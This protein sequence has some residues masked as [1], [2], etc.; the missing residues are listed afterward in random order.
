MRNLISLIIAVFAL[1][2]LTG[3]GGGG[4]GGGGG[5]SSLSAITN[6]T[7]S[8]IS[9]RIESDQNASGL[10]VFLMDANAVASIQNES[11]AGIRASVNTVSGPLQSTVTD[12]TGSF[13]FTSV[14]DGIYS[15]V[16]Q[17]GNNRNGITQSVVVGGSASMVEVSVKLTPTGQISGKVNIPAGKR[18][19]QITIYL[20]GTSYGARPADN[21]NFLLTSV[22][23]GTFSLVC[24]GIGLL[25]GTVAN[26]TVQPGATTTL[27][28]VTLSA[29]SEFFVQGPT[30]PQG[31]QGTAGTTGAT[32][33][34]GT[35]GATGATG[36]QGPQGTA[37]TTGATGAQGAAGI[38]IFW[39]GSFA[40][41][42]GS[43]LTNHAYY[44]TAD[45]KSYIFN[46]SAWQLMTVDGSGIRWLNAANA[47]PAG[48]AENDAYRNT[49][50][51]ASYIYTRS[52][53][54]NPLSALV[55]KVLTLPA[56]PEAP[57][58]ASSSWASS[59][60]FPITIQW[61]AISD[62]GEYYILDGSESFIASVT[63]PATTFTKPGNSYLTQYSFRVRAVKVAIDNSWRLESPSSEIVSATTGFGGGDGSAQKPYKIATAEHL[64][65]IRGA[66][67]SDKHFIQTADIS[68]SVADLDGP[69]WYSP[70]ATDWYASPNG[71]EPISLFTGVYDGNGFS[72]NNMV[73]DASGISFMNPV[74]L[75][76]VLSGSAVLKNITMTNVSIFHD[77]DTV[78]ALVGEVDSTSASIQNCRMVSGKVEGGNFLGSIV[79]VNVGQI[80]QCSSGIE[81]EGTGQ[82]IG[83]IVGVN[84]FAG[85]IEGCSVKGDVEGADMVG[86]IAGNNDGTIRRSICSSFQISALSQ[87]AGGISG[88]M[89]SSGLIEQCA[90]T[91]ILI[92]AASDYAGGIAGQNNAGFI[93]ESFSTA[94]V[95]ADYFAGGIV[96]YIYDGLVSDSYHHGQVEVVTGIIGG[97]AGEFGS[98]TSGA[99]VI[100]RCYCATKLVGGTLNS[101]VVTPDGDRGGIAG[102][103]ED[104]ELVVDS[105]FSNA[106]SGDAV[107]DNGYGD[108][109]PGLMKIRS[110]YSANWDLDSIWN[111]ADK[112]SFP[113]L[114]NNPF[115]IPLTSPYDGGV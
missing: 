1:S 85:L 66:S 36:P 28:D 105:F 18:M 39:R 58:I 16:A 72:I 49:L 101:A 46:G 61:P 107:D 71:W 41:A 92:S 33:A 5:G 88:Q 59:A 12:S 42:P 70:A 44:N 109:I 25:P 63:A 90:N 54:G 31:P 64:N 32:G 108:D 7:G 103:R 84:G 77:F 104:D 11:P 50:D 6:G 40:A 100:E 55:W 93:S 10:P 102:I 53:S 27:P 95:K 94:S 48:P 29:D 17:G 23:A 57:V 96:G 111:I 69:T 19:D 56:R 45:K 52:V 24:A 62:V 67:F 110:T 114:R 15:I 78:A 22:P 115:S 73:I 21:G 43:P 91:S 79:G 76:G 83:G 34:T 60:G 51:G 13:R 75:I 65:N 86:G 35:T 9:G 14:P 98:S 113:Y 97:V 38:S 68:L 4:G 106:I 30:G 3:C 8:I 82:Q 112:A 99:T 20:K 47:H 87:L 37:G 89:G 2:L 26:L 81:I 74:G 80:S